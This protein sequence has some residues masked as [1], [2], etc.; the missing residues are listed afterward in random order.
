MRVELFTVFVP[1]PVIGF[2]FVLHL[3]DRFAGIVAF[4]SGR[5]FAHKFPL[6]GKERLA[7][8]MVCHT[9]LGHKMAASKGVLKGNACKTEHNFVIAKE[10][11]RTPLG[12][13]ILYVGEL[14]VRG[15]QDVSSL[16]PPYYWR[17][18]VT[19]FIR[20]GKVEKVRHSPVRHLPP[21]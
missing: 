4:L 16:V 20:L 7:S 2:S 3:G 17:P 18:F 10:H 1:A 11:W 8:T 15:T 12:T 9:S 21:V 5:V 13:I 14:M 19:V 6:A